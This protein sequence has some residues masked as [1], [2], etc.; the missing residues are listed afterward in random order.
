M[1]H[2]NACPSVW[3]TLYF[4]MGNLLSAKWIT[5]ERTYHWFLRKSDNKLNRAQLLNLIN[6]GKLGILKI[7]EVNVDIYLLYPQQL[8]ICKYMQLCCQS[9]GTGNGTAAT[10][11]ILIKLSRFEM[12]I[13][14]NF[15]HHFQAVRSDL[16]SLLS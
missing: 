13:R 4:E 16:I 11:A 5:F 15:K 9:T 12:P 8:F 14:L 2:L 1:F 7:H 10:I 6:E 3:C